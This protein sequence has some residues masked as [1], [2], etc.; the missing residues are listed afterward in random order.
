VICI[1]GLTS[2]WKQVVGY[3][4]TGNKTNG[5]YLVQIV[6]S[7]VKKSAEVGLNVVAATSDMGSFNRAM[8]KKTGNFCQQ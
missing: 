6:E 8:W 4:F 2:R 7:V 5:S 1:S 3:Y